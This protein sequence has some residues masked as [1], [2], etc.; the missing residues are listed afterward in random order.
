VAVVVMTVPVG[1]VHR[2][3]LLHEKG[4]RATDVVGVVVGVAVGIVGVVIPGDVVDGAAG[5][6]P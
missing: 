5:V 1:V 3:R 2:S 4:G 6:T